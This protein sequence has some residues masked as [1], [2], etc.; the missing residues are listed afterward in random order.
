MVPAALLARAAPVSRHCMPSRVPSGICRSADTQAAAFGVQWRICGLRGIV[1]APVIAS[2]RDLRA[3]AAIVSA[4]RPDVP[5]Q[6]GLPPSLLGDLMRQVRCDAIGF[7][8]FDSQRRET[9][10]A[11]LMPDGGEAVAAGPIPVQW[12][13]FWHCQPCSY[14]DRTGDL[15][16]VVKISDFYSARQW[17]AIG[18]RCGIRRPMGFEHDLMLTLPA[19]PGP[20]PALGQTVRLFCLRG[21]GPDFSERDRALLTLL[22]PHLHQA[23]LEAER[24]RHPAP[25][26]TP[27]QD[28]LLRL[29]ASGHTN[30]QI[31]R[32][33][34][35]T[36][37]TVRSHLE[38]IYKRLD[39]S[40]RTAAVT[41]AFEGP[42]A[43]QP[44]PR[45]A[46]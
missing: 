35:I 46:R 17:H 45:A 36:E 44:Q 21:R 4:D 23:W 43:A 29:L 16:S 38:E 18:N 5:A 11:Q 41:R 37:G 22:R 40:G 25:R 27:R 24:H 26:L 13:H 3:L 8:G 32:R 12:D 20:V 30:A 15:R 28:D 2:G 19:R 33:L 39:V 9:W 10:S 42:A 1:V 7:A 34:G 14:P 6:G 31:G